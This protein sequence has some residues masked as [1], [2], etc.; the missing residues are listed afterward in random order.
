MQETVSVKFNYKYHHVNGI[1][2]HVGHLGP[3]GGEKLILLHGFPEF[4]QSWIQQAEFFAE[5]GYHV[6]VP[7]QRGYNLSEK[8]G[9]IKDY[10]LNTLAADVAALI[11]SFSTRPVAIAGHDW[12]GGV[13]W[14]LA[15]RHP[16]LVKKLIILNMPHLQVMRENVRK[17]PIQILKSL[18]AA[19]FQLPFIP[20]KICSAFNY[21]MLELSMVKSARPDIFSQ[22]YIRACKS[23]WHQ[24]NALSSMINWYRA[25]FQIPVETDVNIQVPVL[26]LWGAKDVFLTTKMAEQ[27]IKRCQKGQL[28]ILENATHWLHH[29]EPVLVNG[30]ILAFLKEDS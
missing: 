24:P 9:L 19:F 3:V 30:Y 16:E 22:E 13:A 28:I 25:F 26:M 4:S 27:S 29:E 10:K 20:E 2:L 11:M 17:N 12:G 7:D 23:A 14:A 18:Y 1:T 6:I 5:N 8:P 15:Q 21:K